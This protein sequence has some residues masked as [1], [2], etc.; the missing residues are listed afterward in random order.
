[1]LGFDLL[2]SFEEMFA[3]NSPLL[4]TLCLLV[5]SVLATRSPPSDFN[6]PPSAAVDHVNA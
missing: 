4:S 3:R 5:L 1:M 6:D 2:S